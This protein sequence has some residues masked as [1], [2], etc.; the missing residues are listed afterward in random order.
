[1]TEQ[2]SNDLI[3][4]AESNIQA[5]EKLYVPGDADRTYVNVVGMIQWYI[6]RL[7]LLKGM[8]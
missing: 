7:E 8:N 2:T 1:M 3:V 5:L 6:D 4:K